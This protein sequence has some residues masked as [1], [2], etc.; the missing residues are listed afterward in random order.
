MARVDL[1]CTEVV[2]AEQH[3]PSGWSSNKPRGLQRQWKRALNNEKMEAAGRGR[4][5]MSY[6]K[7]QCGG[8]P[9]GY[10]T[11]KTSGITGYP[12]SGVVRRLD[13][14]TPPRRPRNPVR[15]MRKR[16][17]EA[18]P[19]IQRPPGA[20]SPGYSSPNV[21]PNYCEACGGPRK[22][23]VEPVDIDPY[24]QPRVG[25][26]KWPDFG[27]PSGYLNLADMTRFLAYDRN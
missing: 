27:S 4:K 24:C 22:C 8:T 6:A 11:L 23:Y 18:I 17:E 1:D 13:Y 14:A 2:G 9:T 3:V 21:S 19:C 10:E 16:L 5:A 26:P 7:L 15:Y 20:Y 12:T 25:P